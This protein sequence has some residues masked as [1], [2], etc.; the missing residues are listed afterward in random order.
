MPSP[1]QSTEVAER[2]AV[3]AERDQA[4]AK[5]AE[6]G[7]YIDL[8]V[9]AGKGSE[10]YAERLKQ[11][12]LAEIARTDADVALAYRLEELLAALDT[13]DPSGEGKANDK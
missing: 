10:D 7:A 5:V 8:L 1:T 12:V 4:I 9:K 6:Q 11:G 13:L 2:E 3:E